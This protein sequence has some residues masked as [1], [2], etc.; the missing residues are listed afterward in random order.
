MVAIAEQSSERLN[1]TLKIINNW[2]TVRQGW[3]QLQQVARALPNVFAVL[4]VVDLGRWEPH[5]LLLGTIRLKKK[6]T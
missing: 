5:L 3:E 2:Q 1:Y 4:V 6:K